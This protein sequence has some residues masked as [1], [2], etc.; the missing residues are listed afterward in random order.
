MMENYILM[1]LI[2]FIY[3]LEFIIGLFIYTNKKLIKKVN[4]KEVW[5]LFW[6]MFV[7]KIVDIL[8]TIYF[9]NKLDV[10]FEGNIIA[11]N[12]MLQLGVIPGMLLFSILSLPIMFFWFILVNYIFKGKNKLGWKIFKAIIISITIIVI[13]INISA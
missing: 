5:K 11:R 7:L 12:I 4:L 2:L 9:I 8:S 6:I 13:L 10:S 1:L 3:I